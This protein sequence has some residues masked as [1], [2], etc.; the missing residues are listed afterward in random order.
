MAI[1]NRPTLIQSITDVPRVDLQFRGPLKQGR[2]V[3]GYIYISIKQ[4]EL[5]LRVKEC[6][7][8]QLKH[9]NLEYSAAIVMIT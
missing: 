6:L 3:V 1:S 9:F 2:G 5:M 4:T 8:S 7:Y